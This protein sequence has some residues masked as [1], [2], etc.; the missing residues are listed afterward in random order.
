MS[1]VSKY[2]VLT[3][4]FATSVLCSGSNQAQATPLWGATAWGGAATICTPALNNCYD[5]GTGIPPVPNGGYPIV[6]MS[7]YGDPVEFAQGGATYYF[8]SASSIAD[9]KNGYLSVNVNVAG[10]ANAAIFDTLIFKGLPSTGSAIPF[11]MTGTSYMNSPTATSVQ[12]F[13]TYFPESMFTQICCGL[14]TQTGTATRITSQPD[15]LFSATFGGQYNYTVGPPGTMIYNDIP[16]VFEFALFAG[17]G[18]S[19]PGYLTVS[20][21]ISFSLP[22]GASFTSA[23]GLFLTGQTVPEPVTIAL[24]GLGLAGLGFARRW[25]QQAA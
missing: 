20:D 3:L 6:G 2:L 11:T 9:L 4:M 19:D 8:A 1:S 14:P 16:Y 24:V 21:P 5:Q 12:A 22:Q 13:M 7:A 15:W 23:S 17:A 10:E 25:K 18:G